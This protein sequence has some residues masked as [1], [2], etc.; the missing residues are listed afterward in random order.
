MEN[1]QE[2]FGS[3]GVETHPDMEIRDALTMLFINQEAEILR[4][5][6]D[7]ETW[8]NQCGQRVRLDSIN[9]WGNCC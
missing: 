8:C 2:F 7:A 1:L 5:N 3:R 6:P 9:E 4:Q